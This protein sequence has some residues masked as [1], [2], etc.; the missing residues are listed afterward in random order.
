MIRRASG[1]SLFNNPHNPAVNYK[2]AK[3]CPPPAKLAGNPTAVISQSADNGGAKRR[4][5]SNRIIRHKLKLKF[6]NIQNF[7]F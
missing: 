3:Y 4:Q 5:M 1:V 7:D 6:K 2:N